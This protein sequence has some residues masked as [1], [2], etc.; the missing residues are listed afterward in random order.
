M[1][2]MKVKLVKKP[3]R[4][5]HVGEKFGKLTAIE[6]AGH[7]I[8]TSNQAIYYKFLCDC[9]NTQII[10]YTQIRKGIQ[11]Q[12][13][14][15]SYKIGKESP[16]WKGVGDLS[17]NL[18]NAYWH[19][20]N[21]KG[22]KFDLSL[23]YL[24]NLFEQQNRKCALSGLD[25]HFDIKSQKELN[26]TASLDR[27]DSTKGYIK[28]NV[29]WVHRIINRIKVDMPNDLFVYMCNQVT[30][31]HISKTGLEKFETYVLPQS[32]RKKNESARKIR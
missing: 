13:S 16:N 29:Q 14:K 8:D 5:S 18:Y 21:A 10:R 11:T 28:G 17:K 2:T 31:N 9:G 26:K 24:W 1:N 15:C 7:G 19:S 23:K 25:I 4:C 3:E 12:C 30:K 27:I 20:A 6:Y 32:R 22:L